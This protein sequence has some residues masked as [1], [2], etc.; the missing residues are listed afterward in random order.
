[1]ADI[2]DRSV[3]RPAVVETAVAVATVIQ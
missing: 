3:A 2:D 1:L